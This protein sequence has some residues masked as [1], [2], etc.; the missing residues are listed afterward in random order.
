MNICKALTAAVLALSLSSGAFASQPRNNAG[1][2]SQGYK[3][4]PV[5][6]ALI[7]NEQLS[8][9]GQATSLEFNVRQNILNAQKQQHIK[10]F[11]SDV[12]SVLYRNGINNVFERGFSEEKR[13][14]IQSRLNRL[15]QL[16]DQNPVYSNYAVVV[17]NW[18]H[19]FEKD[20]NIVVNGTLVEK[21]KVKVSL[22]DFLTNILSTRIEQGATMYKPTT[23]KIG[24]DSAVL[25]YPASNGSTYRAS[26]IRCAVEFDYANRVINV[27]FTYQPE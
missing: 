8:N 18:E 4:L 25:F 13:E 3:I 14:F 5:H 2:K 19:F 27:F 7:V 23:E 22:Y 11:R 12:R 9:A 26:E 17:K 20:A 24:T 21:N 10:N 15:Q 6:Q 16:A 1:N